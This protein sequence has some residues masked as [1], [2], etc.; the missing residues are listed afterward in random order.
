MVQDTAKDEWAHLDMILKSTERYFGQRKILFALFIDGRILSQYWQ[1]QIISLSHCMKRVYLSSTNK[2]IKYVCWL[3]PWK[4]FYYIKPHIFPLKW[5]TKSEIFV[6]SYAYGKVTGHSSG[7]SLTH[8]KQFR[9]NE[10]LKSK[11]IKN[12]KWLKIVKEM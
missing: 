12:N 1:L 4:L 3:H 7:I 11:I 6:D 8:M 10:T 2:K 9:I 5:W